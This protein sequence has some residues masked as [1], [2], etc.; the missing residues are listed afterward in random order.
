MEFN[1]FD[2]DTLSAN[3]DIPKED[4]MLIALN[5]YGVRANITDNRIRFRIKLNTVDELF[6]MAICVN[7]CET[8]F[9]IVNNEELLFNGESI[10]SI[11]DI[12]EDTCDSTYFRRNKTELTVNSNMRSQCKGCKFCGTHKMDSADVI[13]LSTPDRFERYIETIL[14]INNMQ[15]FE[16]VVRITLCT[17][18]FQNE[19]EL[20]NHIL[21]VN[22]SFK[23]YGFSKRIR[24][25]GSQLRSDE[26]M[27]IIKDN[28]NS[29]SIS[30][31]AERFSNRMDIMRPEK[32]ELGIYKIKEL[33][34]RAKSYG[35]STN[36]LYILGLESLKEME[37]GM[38]FLKG[39]INR[40]P[41]IQ[42][43]QNFVPEH[44][45]YRIIEAKNIEYYLQARKIIEKLF[46]DENYRPRSWENYRG[47]FY[48]WYNGMPLSCVRI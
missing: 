48:T 30:V 34:E 28:V 9:E 29:F 2:V 43:L 3:Y 33:L 23:K 31:T 15:N 46:G 45:G 27:S 8:P 39:S 38:Q 11:I 17:G 35:F 42:I 1:M 7:T 20:V 4:I 25:I 37:K 40:F 19:K 36:Y 44:E 24:Y 41:G 13:D 14:E 21:M 16:D 22:N 5:R 32:A 10:A 26:A 47:L 6:Y 12:N 18:C